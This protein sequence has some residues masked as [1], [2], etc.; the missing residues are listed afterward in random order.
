MV[1]FR[2][3]L[4][5]LISAVLFSGQAFTATV[6]DDFNDNSKDATRWGADI[7]FG[8]GVLTETN[9]QLEYTC[10]SGTSHDEMDR[11]WV[12]TGFPYNADWEIQLDV[13][14]LTSPSQN[15]QYN[16]FGIT[17]SSPYMWGNEIIAEVYASHLGGP[18]QRNGF[19]AEL[20]NG[21]GTVGWADTYDLGVTNGA[22]RMVFDSTLKVITV[23]YDIDLSDGYQ[24]VQYGSFGLAGTGGANGNTDW[25]LTEADQFFVRIRGA[26]GNM[27]ITSGQLFGDNFTETGG[28]VQPSPGPSPNEGTIGT[29]FTLTDSNF[30][31]KK[32]MVL[33]GP[34]STKITDW[35]T[36]AITGIMTNVPLPVGTYEVTV[37]PYVRNVPRTFI[38]AFTVKDPEI[39]SLSSSHGPSGVEITIN[40][41]FFGTKKGKVYLEYQGK[42]QTKK[43][44]CSV[45]SW[46]MNPTT[47]ESEIKFLVPNGLAPGPYP[48]KVTNK[49][50]TGSTTFTID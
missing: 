6:G 30:G 29:E 36:N 43:K 37:M 49:A 9:G 41:Q 39:G 23:F 8:H 19:Y 10:G 27:A 4:I 25:N 17:I 46:I 24:W 34:A 13:V 18:P 28:M 5:G 15:N 33:I 16:V 40:G 32:G 3:L 50:G 22:V 12:L 2:W 21:G 20:D 38:G 42:G 7:Q 26:S 47:G 1:K 45:T 31:T 44:N 35:K 14:N 11:P 48:L